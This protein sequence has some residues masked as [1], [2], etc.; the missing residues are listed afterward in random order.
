MSETIAQA[1]PLAG[2][3]RAQSARATSMSPRSASAESV[4][5]V[6]REARRAATDDEILGINKVTRESPSNAD[7]IVLDSE[8][9]PEAESASA[10]RSGQHEEAIVADADANEPDHLRTALHAN[11]ELRAAWHEAQAYRETFS[12]PEE[13]R[14]ATVLLADFNRMDALFFSRHPEDHVELARAVAHLD[15]AAFASLARAMNGLAAQTHRHRANPPGNMAAESPAGVS[16]VLPV[17]STAEGTPIEGPLL[18]SSA[19]KRQQDPGST[20]NA[21]PTQAQSE[22]FHA[23]NISAVEGVLEAIESQV[24]RLLP[25]GVSKSARNR[26]V[27]EIYRELD[28]TLRSN[29]DL[30][31][32]M[33]EAFRSGSLDADHQRAVVSLITSRARQALPGVAKRVLNEWTSTLVAANQERRARQRTAERRVDI[34]GAGGAA[35]DGRRS[36]TPREIDYARMSDADILN[37]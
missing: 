33:R 25:E 26:V 27:G 29:R 34:A 4:S 10:R 17:T 36:M 37:L 12:T 31:R 2:R 9:G 18:S 23:A 1:T 15:P 21:A 20:E 5:Q 11:P 22:F 6:A 19:E 16:R 14:A 24:E 32:Q 35:N 7:Q 28:S 30:A 8:G 13:A 3:P